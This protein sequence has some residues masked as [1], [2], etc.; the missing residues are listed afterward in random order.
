MQINV[1]T[2]SLNIWFPIMIGKI[3]LCLIYTS[4]HH[5]GGIANMW[6]GIDP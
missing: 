6:D 3:T 2:I 1:V 5:E 4:D